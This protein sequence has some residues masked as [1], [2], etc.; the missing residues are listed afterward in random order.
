MK[1]FYYFILLTVFVS[2]VQTSKSQESK[3]KMT[4]SNYP[5][6]FDSKNLSEIEKQFISDF[7]QRRILFDDY[8]IVNNMNLFTCPGCGYPTL[9][10]RG[11]YDICAVCNWEDDN[12]DDPNAD[13]IWGGPNHRL[14]LTENR[15]NIGKTLNNLA[16]SL[17]GKINQ[18]PK[19]VMEIFE[20]H[21]IRMASLDEDKLM[22]ARRSDPI[23]IEY[24]NKEK[25]LLTDLIRR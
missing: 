18:N 5:E 16:D 4:E 24:E 20:N 14:S 10:E 6:K 25:E 21:K 23:W 13:E 19:Q 7:R 8:I 15:I 2:C 9:S 22:H 3:N 11:E 17:E 1:I 12:Q